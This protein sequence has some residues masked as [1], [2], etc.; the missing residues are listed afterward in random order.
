MQ[1][2]CPVSRHPNGNSLPV[3]RNA[4][5]VYDPSPMPDI[6]SI[7]TIAILAGFLYVLAGVFGFVWELIGLLGRDQHGRRWRER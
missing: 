6:D 1:G 2:V 4:T 7:I 5:R 3:V